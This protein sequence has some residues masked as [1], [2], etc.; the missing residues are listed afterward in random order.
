MS[1]NTFI[2]LL[3]SGVA[4]GFAPE[5]RATGSRHGFAPGFEPRIWG[6]SNWLLNSGLTS[7]LRADTSYWKCEVRSDRQWEGCAEAE[8]RSGSYVHAVDACYSH[9]SLGR[10][11][12]WSR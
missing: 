6:P 10:D 8:L 7:A 12:R 3:V 4:P 1:M 9:A 5:V 2:S 11:H